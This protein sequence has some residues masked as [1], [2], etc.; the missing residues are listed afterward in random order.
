MATVILSAAGAAI[1]GSIGGTALGLSS[2]AIGR[3]IGA[4]AGKLIDQSVMG[5]GSDPVDVGKV[6]R[7]R[8]TGASEGVAIHRVQGRVRLGG[9]VIWASDFV[10]NTTTSGGGGKGA[11]SQPTTTH[12]SYSVSLALALCEGEISSVGRV[13]A[14]GQEIAPDDL[15]MTVYTGTADQMPDP[16][17][18]AIEGAGAV[19]AYRG[20][21]YVVCENI[22][23]ERF[24]NRVPQFSFEVTRPD[25]ADPTAMPLGVE[26]VAL[27]PGTGEYALSPE[28]VYYANAQGG[29]WAAN[30]NSPSGM[31][32]FE[33][34]L[35]Q[36]EAELPNCR[37]ASLVV[38]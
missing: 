2:V 33:T 38:S 14:D 22:Q 30:V 5:L 31:S 15:N 35:T 19:P 29:R 36:L 1:G 26:A 4:T 28:P 20:T 37:A 3:A 24:G 25:L 18:E 16:L 6:D 7:F 12:Y 32:D 23:L 9:Q 17:M 13:W 10:E 34:S 21:A 11:P 27:V 8:L